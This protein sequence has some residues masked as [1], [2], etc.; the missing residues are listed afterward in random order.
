MVKAR[1]P[2][3][4]LSRREAYDVELEVLAVIVE[5]GSLLWIEEFAAGAA[6]QVEE[7]GQMLHL[8]AITA[9]GIHP[10]ERS[11]VEADETL[12]VELD[13]LVVPV[14]VIEK[15]LDHGAMLASKRLVPIKEPKD[16]T[17]RIEARLKDGLSSTPD[18]RG[19]T[20]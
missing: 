1:S 7:T 14:G 17:N 11:L 5:I 9:I 19:A 16:A 4:V 13:L 2:I 18:G 6:I 3:A 20:P 10:Q 12:L 15:G 8:A